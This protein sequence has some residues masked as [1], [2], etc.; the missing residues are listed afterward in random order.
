MRLMLPHSASLAAQQSDTKEA[1]QRTAGASQDPTLHPVASKLSLLDVGS[2]YDP[3]C[4]IMR[5]F[6]DVDVDDEPSQLRTAST[7]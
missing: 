2:C 6:D 1:V 3:F 5:T 4:K 7:L